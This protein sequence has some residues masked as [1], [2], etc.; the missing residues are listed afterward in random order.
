MTITAV[1]LPSEGDPV[2]L[3]VWV[4][5]RSERDHAALR[6]ALALDWGID[7][8]AALA[9]FRAANFAYNEAMQAHLRS[10]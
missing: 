1:V 10:A 8:A 4:Q 2:L 9:T 7:H 5:A 3:H 6:L